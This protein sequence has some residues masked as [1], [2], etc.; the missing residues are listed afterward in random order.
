MY[1]K[2]SADPTALILGI[3]S[4]VIV[5]LGCCCGVFVLASFG[6]SIAGIVIA[7]KGL[8]EYNLAPE[9]YS[10]NSKNNVF[11]GKI[12]NIIALVLS[13]LFLLILI[14]YFVL[15]GTLLTGSALS[16]KWLNEKYKLKDQDSIP[17]VYI[18]S[19]SEGNERFID[20]LEVELENK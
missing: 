3:V 16:E 18:D 12:L 15:M 6:L 4:L 9:E 8:R 7:N 11:I 10:Y 5:F 19:T 1:K 2:V 13:S 17:S 20:S 14:A